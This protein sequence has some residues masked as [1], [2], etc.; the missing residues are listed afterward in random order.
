MGTKSNSKIKRL[1]TCL[2]GT[3]SLDNIV[4]EETNIREPLRTNPNSIGSQSEAYQT[5]DARYHSIPSIRWFWG[6]KAAPKPPTQYPPFLGRGDRGGMG[7]KLQGN[8]E[9]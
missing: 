5:V 6:G 7:S 4:W 8:T 2:S 3:L 1:V 9:D